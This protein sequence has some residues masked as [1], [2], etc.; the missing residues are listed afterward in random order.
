MGVNWITLFPTCY[1]ENI[2]STQIRCRTDTST[3][4]DDDLTHAIQYAHGL[5]IRVMLKPHIDVTNDPAHWRGQIDFGGDEGG[6]KAWFASYTDFITHYATLAQRTG[7]DYFAVG[8]ELPNTSSRADQW[9]AVVKAVRAIYSG[10]LIY[11]AN[12]GEEVNVTWWDAVDAIGVDAYYP[13]TQT[14]QPTLAQ[15]K[16][17][18]A[19]IASQ[20]GQLSRRW[21]R[22]I[23]F[24]EI[25]YRSIDGTNQAPYDYQ[26]T[27]SVD[28]Q[29]QADCYQA[30]FE[31]LTGQ[32]WWRGVF[33]HNWTT[34]PTQGGP[35]DEDYTANNKPAED[36][37]RK[38][39]G[40]SLRTT[41]TPTSALAVDEKNQLVIYDD[42]LGTG[43]ADWSWNATVDWAFRDIKQS[44]NTAIK[45]SLK[46]WGALSLH[47]RGIDTSPYRWLEFYLN[48]GDNTQRQLAVY[49]NDESDTEMSPKIELVNPLLIEG[50]KLL[51]NQWQRI[52][53]PLTDM[54]ASQTTI[55]R[56]N[57]KDNT[58]SG[59]KDFY[60][61]GIRLIGALSQ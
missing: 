59:Q 41:P 60:V 44:G 24:P 56:V 13:L 19:P 5:G 15:L 42:S 7:A 55:V 16:A 35:Y 57:I 29:E 14:N 26:M 2:T 27:G 10:P 32:D 9:R 47:H 61:D 52:R 31:T 51:P 3:P 33:W 48:V 58:G 34:I 40:A 12:Q 4:T 18:W 28:L 38:F 36:V 1:Q 53:I 30:V 43:W 17:A 22:P 39:Y 6:W 49:F 8:T 50:G 11:A 23:V 37:L 45:V 25:G 21:G 20:L 54:G 46:N